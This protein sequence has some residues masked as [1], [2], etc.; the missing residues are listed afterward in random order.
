MLRTCR[1]H[2][3]R[4]ELAAEKRGEKR[5]EREKECGFLL[6]HIPGYIKISLK[7][8]YDAWMARCEKERIRF[9][10]EVFSQRKVEQFYEKNEEE[11]GGKITLHLIERFVR[12]HHINMKHF[13]PEHT[14][15]YPSFGDFMARNLNEKSNIRPLSDPSDEYVLVSPCDG[16]VATFEIFKDARDLWIKGSKF[17]PSHLMGNSLFEKFWNPQVENA[18]IGKEAEKSCLKTSVAIVRCNK[19]DYHGIHAPISGEILDIEH[20]DGGLY[21]VSPIVVNNNMAYSTPF[22]DLF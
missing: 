22:F 4:A 15:E 7:T 12:M 6:G 17:L 13:T 16:R 10:L 2:T 3:A 8:M 21:S 11:N 18:K 19:S 20:L 9:Q 1:R 5:G 14:S